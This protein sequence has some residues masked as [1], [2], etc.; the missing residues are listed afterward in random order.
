M[1]K[2]LQKTLNGFILVS[3]LCFFQPPPALATVPYQNG[4]LFYTQRFQPNSSFLHFESELS[5]QDTSSTGAFTYSYP[6]FTPPGRTNLE[7]H[8]ALTYNS[9]DKSLD[10]LYGLGWNLNIPSIQRVNKDGV[11]NLYVETYF[12]SSLSGELVPISLSDSMHGT[13]ATK[14]ESGDFY[15]YFYSSVD[16]SWSAISKDGTTYTFGYSSDSR[17]ENPSDGTQI[18]KWML[19]KIQDKNGNFIRYEYTKNENQIYPSALNYTGYGT[20]DCP[21]EVNFGWETRSGQQYAYSAGFRVQTDKRLQNIEI[22]FEGSLVREYEFSYSPSDG[23]FDLL[24]AITESAISS[25]GTVSTKPATYFTYSEVSKSWTQKTGYYTLGGEFFSQGSSAGTY[26]SGGNILDITG[27]ALPDFFMRSKDSSSWYLETFFLNR[28]DNAHLEEVDDS[29]FDIPLNFFDLDM[30]EDQ[31][32]RFGDINGDGWVDF[33]KAYQGSAS[34]ENGVYINQ[35]NGSWVKDSSYTVPVTFVFEEPLD[36]FVRDQG[37]RLIDI[38]G[39]GFADLVHATE[40]HGSVDQYVYLNDADGTGWSYTSDYHIPVG[41]IT[42]VPESLTSSSSFPTDRGVEFADMNNDGLLDFVKNY[43]GEN[44]SS[45]TGYIPNGVYF[46]QGDGTW[47]RSS[48]YNPYYAFAWTNTFGITVDAGLRL[49]DINSDGLPDLV[50]SSKTGSSLNDDVYLNTGSSWIQDSSYSLPIYYVDSGYNGDTGV[51][52]DDINGD[53]LLDFVRSGYGMSS[54]EFYTHDGEVPNLLTGIQNPEGATSVITYGTSADDSGESNPQ[55]PFV[56]QTVTSI[57]SNDGLGNESTVNFSYEDGSYYYGDQMHRSFAG[58][59]VVTKTENE[60]TTEVHYLQDSLA[61]LGHVYETDIYDVSGQLYQ[62]TIDTWTT[63]DLGYDNTYIYKSQTLTMNYDGGSSHR[64]SAVTYSYNTS[65]GNLDSTIQYGEVEGNSDGSFTDVIEL[66]EKTTT[67]FSYA[68]DSIGDIRNKPSQVLVTNESGAT[69]KKTRYYYD[70]STY[71]NVSVGNLTRHSEWYDISSIWLNTDY[72]YNSYGLITSVRNPRAYS[73]SF[74]YD[75][76]N[77]YPATSTNAKGYSSSTSYDYASGQ[78]SIHTDENG[79]TNQNEYDGF[80][81]LKSVSL[82]DPNTGTLTVLSTIS[83]NDSSVPISSTTTTT[84]NSVSSIAVNYFDGFGRLV[85]SNTLG[86]DAVYSTV[87]F[88]YDD[89]GNLE[90][91]SFPYTTSSSAFGRSTSAYSTEMSY[92][93]LNR[94]LT[95][96]T[97]T[98]TTSTSYSLWDKTV[99]DPNGNTKVYSYDAAQRLLAVE[100]QNGSETYTTFYTYDPLGQLLQSTDARSNVRDF[101][102]DSLGRKTSE[103]DLH[104][105]TE[106]SYGSWTYGYDKN[107]NLTS[108]TDPRSQ[109]LTWA[110]DQ[111]DRVIY[112]DWDGS[113]TARDFTYTYDTGFLGKMKLYKITSNNNDQYVIYNNYDYLGNSS[114]E[115][116]YFLKPGLTTY[117][118]YIFQTTYDLL[119]RPTKVTYPASA[120]IVNYSYNAT[121]ALEKVTRGATGATNVITDIDYS[122]VGQISYMAYA[123]GTTTANTFSAD[124]GYRLTQSISRGKYSTSL[125]GAFTS[126]IQNLA[127]SY[128]ADGNITSIQDTSSVPTAKTVTYTYD[129]LNRLLTASTTG[130]A[131]G[132]YSESFSY[133]EV[134]NLTYRS[135]VGAMTYD[136]TGLGGTNP[137]AV[138]NVGGTA[139]SY[140]A[141]G[142]L[143][144]DGT[145][146]YTWDKRNRL[147]SSG[148]ET[149]YYDVSGQRYKTAD[150]SSGTAVYNYYISPYEEIRNGVTTYY[151]LAGKQR[152]ASAQGGTY[153]YIIPDH[154]GSTALTTNSSGYVTQIYDYY[155]YGSELTNTQLTTT[156]AA[157]SFTDKELDDTLGLYYF[158]ARWYNPTIGRFVSQDPMQ[159]TFDPKAKT[160]VTS[161]LADPQSLNYYAYTRN[162]PVNLVDPTGKFWDTLWDAANLVYDIFLGTEED[163]VFDATAAMIPGLPAGATKADDAFEAITKYSDEAAEFTGKVEGKIINTIEDASG[164][165]SI[166]HSIANGHAWD[167][168]VIRNGEFGGQGGMFKNQEEFT[169]YIEQVMS[170]PSEMKDIAGGK[171]AFWDNSTQAVVIYDPHNLKDQGTF[172]QP[173]EGK[174]YFNNLKTE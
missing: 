50:Y 29:E 55:L 35:K 149:F 167:K 120:L 33:V 78:I 54:D 81:R 17:V 100:E 1:K 97:P 47:S 152:V 20:S 44:D 143:T 140:D 59:A 132:N 151:I 67:T 110:Y 150:N 72:T 158:E 53:G 5:G 162:N 3:L 168:H 74:T 94:P 16:N 14:L 83:Y 127:Y 134:G 159:L 106:T 69:L 22:Q 57:T 115:T 85:E 91:Q 119:S 174:D 26:S 165:S 24:E 87:D 166:A 126:N 8:L 98:G 63:T 23:N 96:T 125:T 48:G 124:Q 135:D 37:T 118:S 34:G 157:Y 18:F 102:Y 153:S 4:E 90:R 41:F 84:V 169:G 133:D 76:Y 103:T 109:N 70:G 51:R 156:D 111:L 86:E 80:G 121:G 99:I 173:K 101:H 171:K 7:P 160:G 42:Y 144:S 142:N 11:E 128:D 68:S 104:T 88:W 12:T 49:H 123:N 139:Y 147:S 146:S 136:G 73:T 95:V 65:N 60:R 138:T 172:F 155:P 36:Y 21:F 64:D 10:S 71:G 27:D 6:L 154:L 2:Y 114:K 79:A 108:R 40:N 15:S 93:I 39:D 31:G 32:V 38:N 145:H 58:F 116:C 164:K 25:D 141:N 113:T 66:D 161:L 112:E 19:E 122:P 43:Q 117:N 28:G 82:P 61:E 163:M 77:L 131:A 46:N 137:H 75:S 62:K 130:H 107:G 148:P 13:Y 52:A 170:N 30:S 9:Q 45:A 105:S 56:V 129:E 92:D 89:F